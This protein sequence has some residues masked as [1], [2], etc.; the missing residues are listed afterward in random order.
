MFEEVKNLKAHLIPSFS[1][2]LF[3]VAQD[4][5]YVEKHKNRLC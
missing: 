1:G 3:V 5:V 4:N 2:Y